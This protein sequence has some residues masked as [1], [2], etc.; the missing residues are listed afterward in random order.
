MWRT[1]LDGSNLNSESGNSKS[2]FRVVLDASLEVRSAVVY[3]TLIVV[4]TLVPVFFLEGLAGSFF[5]WRRPT[6]SRSSLHLL[7]H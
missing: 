4:L 7:L 3:A 6:S 1:S 2:A 5:R